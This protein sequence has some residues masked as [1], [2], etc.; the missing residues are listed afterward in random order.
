MPL[1]PV[2]PFPLIGGVAGSLGLVFGAHL[3]LAF[4]ALPDAA[5]REGLT[6]DEQAHAP[7]QD[8]SSSAHN[9]AQYVGRHVF[10]FVCIHQQS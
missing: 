6:G 2:E 3:L 8:A 7:P 4:I 9:R 10:A 1:R 5:G